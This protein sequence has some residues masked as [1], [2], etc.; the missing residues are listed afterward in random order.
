MID[1]IIRIIRTES[2]PVRWLLFLFI[3]FSACSEKVSE[4]APEVPFAFSKPEH[5]PEPVYNF[6][7]NPVTKAGFELGRKLFYEPKLSIDNSVSC[8]SCHQQSAGFTQ[9]GH[10]VSHGIFNRLGSRNSPPVMNLA[11][12]RFFMWDGGIFHLDFLPIAPITNPVEM[13]EDIKNVVGKLQSDARYPELFRR[14]FGTSDITSA[15]MYQALSQFMLMCISADSPYDRWRLGKDTL[16]KDALLGLSLFQEHCS[17]C[18]SGELFMDNDFHNNGL[19]QGIFKEDL[20]RQAV[21][22]N[23]SDSRKFKTP[24]LR[25]LQFTAPYMHDGRFLSLRSVLDFYDG[26]LVDSPTLD[27]RLR[28]GNRLGFEL[29]E[30]QKNQLLQFLNA[31]NDNSF[32]NR[33]ELSEMAAFQ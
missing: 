22:L 12:S 8:G 2:H 26:N 10:S 28:N 16:S 33:Y 20:G 17:S 15:R 3:G 13:G 14:A 21:T 31:L 4:P 7:Q 19:G 27:A 23:E 30:V 25:N 32:K 29:S 5:F 11:W 18:H 6:D 1:H 24:S 9:H